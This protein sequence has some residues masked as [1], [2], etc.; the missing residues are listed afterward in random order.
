MERSRSATCGLSLLSPD[1]L[2]PT[3]RRKWTYPSPCKRTI[4]AS[5]CGV[6]ST[7]KGH[8][9]CP[10]EVRFERS[11]HGHVLGNHI[12]FVRIAKVPFEDQPGEE[13]GRGLCQPMS[14]RRGQIAG[15]HVVGN[16]GL[17]DLHGERDGRQFALAQALAAFK[18][19]DG[20]QVANVAGMSG[21]A[22]A[23][24]LLGEAPHEL[25]FCRARR[26]SRLGQALVAHEAGDAELAARLFGGGMQPGRRQ[27]VPHRAGVSDVDQMERR[28]VN[29]HGASG[30]THTP[31]RIG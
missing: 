24:L 29:G 3:G 27:H 14:G 10:V 26:L 31:V 21:E 28:R 5:R 2:R 4:R 11:S 16:D 22:T 12:R 19:L 17:P 18:D 6:E 25:G 30:R 9:V 7:L 23:P 15:L 13:M 1:T 8:L 20:L